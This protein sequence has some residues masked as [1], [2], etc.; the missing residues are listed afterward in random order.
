MF[1]KKKF[2][3]VAVEKID[4]NRLSEAQINILRKITLK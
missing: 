3:F 2:K 1:N 4:K